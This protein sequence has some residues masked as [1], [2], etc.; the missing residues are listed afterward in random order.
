MK[1]RQ[2]VHVVS[3]NA[4]RWTLKSSYLGS[5]TFANQAAALAAA[6]M[7]AGDASKGGHESEIIVQS[8]KRRRKPL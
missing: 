8:R 6:D 4:R 1:T 5:R 7:A 2:A 3:R